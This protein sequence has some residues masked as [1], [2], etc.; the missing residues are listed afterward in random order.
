VK[1][2]TF[3]F[4]V[5]NHQPIGNF[6]EVFHRAY[7]DAYLPFI[8]ALYSRPN[9]KWV[10][11]CTG[12]LWDFISKE[13]P[14]YIDKVSQMVSRGQLELLSG[15][16]YEPILPSIPNN[17]SLGQIRKLNNFIVQ[18][19]GKEPKGMWLAERVWEPQLAKTLVDAGMNYSVVDDAHFAASGLNPDELCGYYTTEDQ[20]AKL[21][22]FPISQKL[23]YTIPFQSP[24]STLDIF[25]E[26]LEKCDNPVA[27]MA[28]D[29][30]KFGLWPGT[31]MHVY[32]HGWLNAFLDMLSSNAH[33]IETATFSDVLAKTSPSGIVYLPTA[34]YFE[35]S[36]WAL[37]SSAQNAF[38]LLSKRFHDDNSVKRFL[39][40]GFWRNFLAKYPEA[41]AMNKKML[42]VS[43][44]LES[45]RSKY[46]ESSLLMA[47]DDLYA[48]Q[49][50]CAYWHGV[51]GGLYSPHL[52]NG[53]YRKL[54]DAEKKLNAL[55][56]P[57]KRWSVFDYNAD[58]FDE[59]IFESRKQNLYI[60][61]NLGGSII[62][63]D[64]L[65]KSINLGNVLTRRYEAYHKK[66][67]EFLENPNAYEQDVKTIHDIVFVKENNLDKY[68]HYDKTQKSSLLDHF[69]GDEVTSESFANN[70][71]EE[72]GNF[73]NASYAYTVD[74]KSIVLSKSGSVQFANGSVALS[75]RKKLLPITNGFSVQYNF[76]HQESM[77]QL[78][79]Y[80]CELNAAFYCFDSNLYGEHKS[81]K[82]W[83]VIDKCSGLRYTIESDVNFDLWVN[84]LETVSLSE[85]GFERTYQGVNLA[86]VFNLNALGKEKTLSIKVIAE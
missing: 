15:G 12:I 39:R 62:E 29:G 46:A 55:T 54:L 56:A 76:I 10:L 11:H 64:I 4:A 80:A 21:N 45:A 63:W 2:A 83:Q 84:A 13:Y 72:I 9:I 22:I 67:K 14:S 28:D 81:I 50:N 24:E 85:S 23:R 7:N 68:L 27:V 77:Q 47:T 75:L 16:Y 3:I 79:K 5:H 30:E 61:P 6:D 78:P 34:S 53:V 41:N 86:L 73:Q 52:R 69:F 17:D 40:G 1:K 44:K 8:D 38:E 25:K 58:G 33:W 57:L 20:G 31:K 66:L 65:D 71:F 42:Y 19:F 82:S 49:C 70:T 36:E 48:G 74:N 60:A 43:R 51:F 32:E 35:M 59:L 26:L 18:T 37:P